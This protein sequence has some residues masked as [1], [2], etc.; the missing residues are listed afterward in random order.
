[1]KYRNI[2]YRIKKK[3]SGAQLCIKHSTTYVYKRL[4]HEIFDSFSSL[5]SDNRVNKIHIATIKIENHYLKK[6][7]NN[8]SYELYHM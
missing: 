3:V 1:L 7:F 4:L 8:I 5:Y 2:G 6:K